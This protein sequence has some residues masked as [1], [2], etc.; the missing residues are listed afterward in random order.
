ML[1]V[2]L[3]SLLALPAYAVDE[4]RE[5]TAVGKAVISGNMTYDQAKG[6]ALNQARALAVE[7]AA[8]VNINSASII[9]DS[10]MLTDLVQTFSYGYLVDETRKTWRGTWVE[11]SAENSP[12]YPVVEV[13][14]TGSVKILPK[15]FFRN[16]L[17]SATLN[18]Q[19]FNDG[20]NV[21]I[22][23]ETKEDMYIVIANYTSKSNII[24][25]FPS[26]YDSN[27]L[28][29]AGHLLTIP[30]DPKT[31][32]TLTVNNYAGHKEDI[33]AFLVFAFPRNAETDKI[34]WPSIFNAG[35]EI[36]YADYFN[37]LLDLPVP[38]IAQQT[39]VYRVLNGNKSSPVEQ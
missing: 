9:Q 25:V 26:S 8:G 10:L 38:S 2:L 35:K 29:R 14:L 28:A 7:Q 1:T 6:Q 19:T 22:S 3:L 36:N 24:P 18:N 23:I 21:Q 12:G 32:V 30:K 13:S 20:D 5:V 33:E 27:N 37:T 15:S 39:L 17:L 34:P 31:A 16:Y 11:D 4:L